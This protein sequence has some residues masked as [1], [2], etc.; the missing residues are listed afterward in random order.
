MKFPAFLLDQ[1]L[2]QHAGAE[3]NLGGSTGPR[4][5]PRQL[6]GL[7]GDSAAEKILT[8]DL[9]YTPTPGSTSLREAIAKMQ[10]VPAEEVIVFAGSAEALFHIFY[11]AAQPGANA[12]VP[13]PCFPSHQVIP[14]SL[15]FEI[16]RYHLT[17]ENSYRIDLDEVNSLADRKTKILVV[18]SPTLTDDGR[19]RSG[20]KLRRKRTEFRAQYK[21]SGAAASR[22]RFRCTSF[23]CHSGWRFLEGTLA[24]G[25]APWLDCRT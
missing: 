25:I 13:F 18:N 12:V 11:L 14:E 7:A 21:D 24:S 2:Q 20:E 9:D 19:G 4:W 3:F 5:T 15:G 10:G 22:S 23:L 16:R 6:L 17:R 8:L 1:W